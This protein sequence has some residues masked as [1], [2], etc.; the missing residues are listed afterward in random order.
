M[1]LS[2]NHHY[3]FIFESL[4]VAYNCAFWAVFQTVHISAVSICVWIVGGKKGMSPHFLPSSHLPLTKIYSELLYLP[5]LSWSSCVQSSL[6]SG[7]SFHS[8]KILYNITFAFLIK[9]N[10]TQ[11]AFCNWYLFGKSVFSNKVSLTVSTIIQGSSYA[12]E[13]LANPKQVPWFFACMF[14]CFVLFCLSYWF[15]FLFFSLLWFS[16]VIFCCSLYFSVSPEKYQLYEKH[17]HLT[18]YER[19]D[20]LCFKCRFVPHSLK[21]WMHYLGLMIPAWETI[22]LRKWHK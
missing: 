11:E 14:L 20:L 16:F 22:K 2:L 15:S 13:K 6:K 12:Q 3:T 8:W 19:S 4:N 10:R 21:F 7:H 18:D 9:N 5:P 1:F 17:F